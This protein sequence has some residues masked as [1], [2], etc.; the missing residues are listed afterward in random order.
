MGWQ[1][2]FKLKQAGKLN[3][4]QSAYWTIPQPVEELYHTANDP[5]ELKNL[6][7]D[8]QHQDRLARMRQATL[9]K[10]REIGDTGLV[11]ESMYESISQDSTVYNYVHD[12]DFPYDDVLNTALVAGD[13]GRGVVR[14][15]QAAMKHDHPVMRYW[16]AT[17]CTIQG[18]AAKVATDALEKLLE[19]PSPAVRV[20]AAEAL[21][22]LG[23]RK[24]GFDGLIE[25]L[26]LT[27]DSVVFLLE[28]LNITECW[29]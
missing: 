13:G 12:S 14:E 15:L 17:G 3:D 9:N 16:G 27:D 1:S 4:V 23:E 7:N 11:P 19:D 25:I 22:V 24:T 8:P 10:M 21:Y 18:E 29:A 2:L 26:K 5:W 20:A 28:A 6:A